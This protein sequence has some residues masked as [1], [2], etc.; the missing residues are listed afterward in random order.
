MLAGWLDNLDGD[1]NFIIVDPLISNDHFARNNDRVTIMTEPPSVLPQ[2]DMIVLAMKPQM[3]PEALP[4]LLEF[5]D[6]NTVCSLLLRVL[7]QRSLN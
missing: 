7:Q 5:A 2:L 4:A 1:L 3:L 6:Q